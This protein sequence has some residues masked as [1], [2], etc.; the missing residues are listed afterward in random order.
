MRPNWGAWL[1]PGASS[2]PELPPQ[3]CPGFKSRGMKTCTQSI[4]CNGRPSLFGRIRVGA[5]RSS[6]PEGSVR[7]EA[8]PQLWTLRRSLQ[9]RAKEKRTRSHGHLLCLVHQ[10]H[11]QR[12]ATIARFLN[13]TWAWRRSGRRS[14]NSRFRRRN[15]DN[16]P[17]RYL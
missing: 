15:V 5:L 4:D 14:L 8:N 1:P 11:R 2:R 9:L 12:E 13:L 17:L 6:V 7:S 16:L 3:G 10:L